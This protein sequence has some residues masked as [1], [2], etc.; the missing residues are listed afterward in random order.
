MQF[1]F[2]NSAGWQRVTHGDH[3]HVL[4]ATLEGTHLHGKVLDLEVASAVDHLD[5]QGYVYL[6][7]EDKV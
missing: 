5:V 6:K 1:D 7:F 2:R 4:V 3:A